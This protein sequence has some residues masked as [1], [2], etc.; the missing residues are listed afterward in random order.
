MDGLKAIGRIALDLDAANPVMPPLVLEDGDSVTVPTR[1][2]FVSVFG[3]VYTESAFIHKPGLT[4][5]DYLEKAGATRDADIDN[6]V[7]V[8][9]DGTVEGSTSRLALW[10]TGINSKKLN[11]GDSLF[12]PALVDRRS[13]Y[14]LFIDGA[15]DWTSLLYQF[16]LGAAAFKT[17]S[18]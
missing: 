15:K 9:A 2:N 3:E 18:N 6:L 12:V 17:L 10:S 13:A 4:V 14:S 8:R 1:P 16:A 11:P 5:G 7:L